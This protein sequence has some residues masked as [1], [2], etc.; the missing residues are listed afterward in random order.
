[1]SWFKRRPRKNEP[2]KPHTPPHRSSPSAEKMM[3]EAKAIGP[4]IKNKKPK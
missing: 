2:Q 4:K 3:E 1:M